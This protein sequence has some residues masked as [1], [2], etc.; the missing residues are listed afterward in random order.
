MSRSLSKKARFEI[1]KRDGFVCQ[2]CGAH[3]PKVREPWVDICGE[4]YGKI[5]REVDRG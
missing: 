3:P 5:E 1:F 2:Y 4:C